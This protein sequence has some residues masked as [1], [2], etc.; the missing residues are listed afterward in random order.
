M[1]F[2][3]YKKKWVAKEFNNSFAEKA[4]VSL[5][6]EVVNSNMGYYSRIKPSC[7]LRDTNLGDYSIVSN[8]THVNATDIGKFD[9]IGYGNYIGLW[10]HNLYVTTHS[11]YLYETSG[12]FVKGYKNYEKDAIRTKICNDV[13][14]GA[15]VVILKGVCVGDGAIIGAG[16][17]VTKDVP[18]YAIVVGNPARKLRYRFG[19]ADIEY[20]INLKWWDLKK[21][22]I[23]DMTEKN[24]W[25]SLDK[26]KNY[27]SDLGY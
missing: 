9:S 23:Q 19:K 26:I 22:I 4:V 11:F 21:E 18:P 16:S 5:G 6:C 15:N 2:K 20:L 10:E 24:L 14:T 12:G 7:H 17:V 3:N 8:S 13:W 25:D 27:L 1:N